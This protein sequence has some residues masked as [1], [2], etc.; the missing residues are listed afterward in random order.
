LLAYGK[1]DF[2]GSSFKLLE[3]TEPIGIWPT[4]AK[5]GVE[6]A[7]IEYTLTGSNRRSIPCCHLYSLS[8]SD[9]CQDIV[10]SKKC[11]DIVETVSVA[12]RSGGRHLLSLE[13]G[14]RGVVVEGAV[15][16]SCYGDCKRALGN[17]VFQ[18]SPEP[19]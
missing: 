11:H 10:D 3:K 15:L 6:T 12:D 1:F 7:P 18:W 19:G 16:M 13:G 17:R 14:N 4:A 5:K 2:Q 8:L 9:K